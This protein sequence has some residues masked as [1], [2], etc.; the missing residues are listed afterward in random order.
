MKKHHIFSENP[1]W[2]F[3]GFWRNMTSFVT[4]KRTITFEI[5]KLF[6]AYLIFQQN[7]KLIQIRM[8]AELN[9]NAFEVGIFLH[10]T[11]A[12]IIFLVLFSHILKKN[13]K[14]CKNDK[15]VQNRIFFFSASQDNPFEFSGEGSKGGGQPCFLDFNGFLN[16]ISRW[17]FI[18]M[19]NPSWG[20]WIRTKTI[21]RPNRPQNRP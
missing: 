21:V 18:Q 8:Y 20:R 10:S 3:I 7:E 4:K 16:T 9:Y 11:C 13:K 14:R 1:T 2:P 15:Y 5:H 6:D 19:K 17:I 12:S